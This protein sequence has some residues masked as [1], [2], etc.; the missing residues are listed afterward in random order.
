VIVH[1]P[2][3]PHFEPFKLLHFE[4]N[5]DPDPVFHFNAV[6]VSQNNADPAPDDTGTVEGN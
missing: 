1:G 2:P 4:F 6:P 3:W 5:A